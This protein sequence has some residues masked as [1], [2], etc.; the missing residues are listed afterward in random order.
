MQGSE[1]KIRK[2]IGRKIFFSAPP[3]G[4]WK[5][6]IKGPDGM[7][8]YTTPNNKYETNDIAFCGS[9]VA[10]PEDSDVKHGDKIYFHYNTMLGQVPKEINGIN[11][12]EVDVDLVFCV[13]REG[14]I[15]AIG[16]WVLLNPIDT[17]E[18]LGSGLF[19]NPFKTISKKVATVYSISEKVTLLLSDGKVKEGDN[20]F[21]NEKTAPFEN[22]IEG[23]KYY[24]TRAK[25]I[26]M[27]WESQIIPG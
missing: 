19:E 11:C 5:D 15:K 17:T 18:V 7:V 24:C 9:V 8:F 6:T 3:E 20:V 4:R 16:E 21:I 10:A 22:E 14:K 12:Y 23:V 25:N 13:V 27:L 1:K 2:S 26:L